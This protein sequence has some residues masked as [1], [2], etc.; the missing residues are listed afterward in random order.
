MRKCF[1]YLLVFSLFVTLAFPLDNVFAKDKVTQYSIEF[2][3]KDV[4]T[5]S[6]SGTSASEWTASI[7][8]G[9][10]YL[11]TDIEARANEVFQEKYGSD[12]SL[13]SLL[14]SADPGSIVSSYSASA[15]ISCSS[16]GAQLTMLRL[17]D[18]S[19]NCSG[20]WYGASDVQSNYFAN[21]GFS[22]IA[23]V[24][25]TMSWNGEGEFTYPQVT[26]SAIGTYYLNTVPA[27]YYPNPVVGNGRVS[28]G[29]R[30]FCNFSLSFTTSA[31]ISTN[32]AVNDI[33]D[34][35][36]AYHHEELDKA[37]SVGS[38]I[39]SSTSELEGLGGEEGKWKILWFPL[40]FTKQLIGVF[41]G[42]NTAAIAA[43]QVVGFRYNED[44]GYLEKV[45]SYDPVPIDEGSTV[46]PL[47]NS[48]TVISF[49]SVSV[50]LLDGKTYKLWDSY[51]FDL[52]T[53]KEQ[54][55]LLFSAIYVVVSIL[56]VYWFVSFLKDK[57]DEVFG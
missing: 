50:P 15:Q 56:E 43:E 17:A 28:C 40:T 37:D 4:Q 45:H 25:S 22:N 42:T 1:C 26:T 11:P 55:P 39:N 32:E 34:N 5:L 53:V 47:P 27:G 46:V 23:S 44:T 12:L 6:F 19:V 18:G 13:S 3:L 41:T 54:F 14:A 8:K 38:D 21:D 48:G 30:S 24:S 33:L 2:Q 49:P 29:W 31:P 10:A 36:E 51:D 57:F 52:A 16:V 7:N 9:K 20:S 35:Q